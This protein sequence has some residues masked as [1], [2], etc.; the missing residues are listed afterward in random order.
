M[1]SCGVLAGV[2]VGQLQSHIR[3]L[4]TGVP[5]RAFVVV[6]IQGL[7]KGS[8]GIFDPRSSLPISRSISAW[9]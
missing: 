9:M 3:A 1:G 4:Q 5:I 7:L 8:D 6:G 2:D